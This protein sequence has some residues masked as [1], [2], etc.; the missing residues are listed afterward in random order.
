MKYRGSNAILNNI[1]LF[2]YNYMQILMQ[3]NE[4]RNLVLKEKP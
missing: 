2:S 4:K 3:K 1:Q